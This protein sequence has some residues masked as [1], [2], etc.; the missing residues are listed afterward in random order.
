MYVEITRTER[1]GYGTVSS[2]TRARSRRSQLT[3]S[4][5]AP[6]TITTEFTPGLAALFTTLDSRTDFGGVRW[7]RFLLRNLREAVRSGSAPMHDDSIAARRWNVRVP[8]SES[9]NTAC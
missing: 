4:R 8:A 3:L 5:L 2:S 1:A 6:Y 7:K 9:T